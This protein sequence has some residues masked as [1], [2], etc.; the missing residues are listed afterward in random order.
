MPLYV[1]Y[2]YVQCREDTASVD[3]RYIN[4]IY[5]YYQYF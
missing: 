5:Y 3:L 1:I 2:D 4:Q